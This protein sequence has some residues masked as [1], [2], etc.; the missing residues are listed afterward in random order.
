M[1]S[2]HKLS[3]LA[4]RPG[5][6]AVTIIEGRLFTVRVGITT[7]GTDL[8]TTPAIRRGVFMSPTTPGMAGASACPGPMDHSDSRFQ[9]TAAGGASADTDRMRARY[10]IGA[11]ARPISISTTASTSVAVAEIARRPGRISTTGRRILRETSSGPLC[12][13]TVRHARPTTCRT[14]Y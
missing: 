11:T 13:P 12:R 14:M 4:T 7:H 2:L 3:T 8:T 10:L 9:D 6:T 5:I 1:T